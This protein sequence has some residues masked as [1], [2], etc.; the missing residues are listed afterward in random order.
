MNCAEVMQKDVYSINVTDFAQQAAEIMAE[1]GVG[2]LPVCDD[3]GDVV[4]AIT[5]R[6]IVTR[7]V[8]PRLPSETAVA[9]VMTHGVSTCSVGEKVINAI[10]QM[11]SDKLTR[12]VCL[13]EQGA[14][15]GV[16]SL[17]DIARYPQFQQELAVA[18]ADVAV[19]RSS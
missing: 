19:S 16:L 6:D 4:G 13:N 1:S 8:A 11:R 17:D 7:I 14:L 12:L 15:A 5:D 10:K 2:F 9:D 3:T 18:E